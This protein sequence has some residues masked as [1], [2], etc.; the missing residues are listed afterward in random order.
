MMMRIVALG[1]AWLVASGAAQAQT[2]I[3]IEPDDY[4]GDIS[5]VP[6]ARL[7]TWR[8]T[9][10]GPVYRRVLSV[11][12]GSWAPTGSR[13]FGHDVTY[14]GEM[15]YHWDNLASWGGAWRC[16]QFAE[17]SL[18]KVFGVRFYTPARTVKLLT[19]VRG[20][21]AQDPVELWAFDTNGQRILQCRLNGITNEVLQTGVLPP[22]RYD[23]MPF[24]LRAPTCG[25][26]VEV[27]NCRPYPNAPPGDCDYV[28]EMRVQRQAADI[29]FVW[30]G[31]TLLG[32][33]HANV[34]TLTYT[35]P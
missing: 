17:C 1:I 23:N 24:T 34:D 29:G 21:Q 8:G 32:N 13:V 16:Y 33:S 28:V 11:E 5:A 3:T 9:N 30:F 4:T 25:A 27:K 19:T 14:Q 10:S 18:F 22:P 7:F 15:S 12:A 20:E 26:V 31:G 2:T 6:G 35:V